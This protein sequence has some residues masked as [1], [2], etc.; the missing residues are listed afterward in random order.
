MEA[1]VEW[2]EDDAP[3]LS[4]CHSCQHRNGLTCSAYPEGV[5]Y[6]WLHGYDKH[7]TIQDD[8]TGKAVFKPAVTAELV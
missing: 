3:S 2:L 7:D 5:P 6:R 1:Q 4:W 8:Q